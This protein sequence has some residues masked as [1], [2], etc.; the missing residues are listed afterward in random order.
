MATV[1]PAP[2]REKDQSSPVWQNWRRV[3]R[4]AVATTVDSPTADNFASLDANGN[5]QDSGYD[6][7]SFINIKAGDT[8]GNIATFNGSG[9]IQD[10]G[11]A[12]S[13]VV[14]N[15]RQIQLTIDDGT[16]ANTLKN[17]VASLYNGNTIAETD[18]VAKGATTGNFTLDANGQYL[19][20]EA[21]GLTGNCL[22]AQGTLSSN[23]GGTAATL[24][25]L[26]TSN[27]IKLALRDSASGALLDLTALV[28]VGTTIEIYILY[29]TST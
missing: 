2:E 6:N 29:L 13:T 7:T 21:A 24:D 25:L 11:T 1:P 9:D 20:V 5:V 15:L 10:S 12:L 3:F 26:A 22:M 28:D 23:P 16:N 27:D 17:T 8:N 18:N 19:I 4:N 14:T